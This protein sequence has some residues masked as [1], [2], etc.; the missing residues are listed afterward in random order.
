MVQVASNSLGDMFNRTL[1][2]PVLKLSAIFAVFSPA[3]L[4]PAQAQIVA[5]SGAVVPAYPAVADLV[6]SAPAV[7]DARIRS[8]TRIKGAEAASV[9]PGHAR[10]YVEA[11]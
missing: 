3:L 5:E 2:P 7:V 4:M 9:A 10:F 8:A 11:D 1:L 6:L